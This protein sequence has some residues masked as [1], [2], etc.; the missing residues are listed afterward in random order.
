MIRA[1]GVSGLAAVSL[2]LALWVAM[3]P[4]SQGA[5]GEAKGTLSH[6]GKA[7]TL[8]HAYLVTGPD[9][10]DSKKM[11]RRL[12]LSGKDLGAKVHGCQTMS[13]TDG[14][15]TEGVVV[16]MDGGPRLNYW[17]ALNDQRVQHSGTR[18]P[19]ALKAS[20]DEL[21]RLAGKL[22]FDDTPSS[23]PKVD[24]EFDATLV[25]EFKTAR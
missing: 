7:V 9:A 15:V 23:G 1:L 11:V 24:V 19:A 18:R 20:A 8:P 5:A 6:K 13:C 21:K 12:I 3:P 25:K 2:I 14:E 16:D 17:M 10:V 22:S 4:A